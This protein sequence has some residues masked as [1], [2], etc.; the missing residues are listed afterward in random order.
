MT[1]LRHSF[2]DET[3]ATCGFFQNK[4][5]IIST[6]R[7]FKLVIAVF[8]TL[9]VSIKHCQHVEI[10]TY[11]TNMNYI[12]L[13][14]LVKADNKNRSIFLLLPHILDTKQITNKVRYS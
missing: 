6:Y 14:W 1:A 4:A 5:N 2:A 13:I 12:L 10:Y 3:V 9:C 8:A 11:M 7:N